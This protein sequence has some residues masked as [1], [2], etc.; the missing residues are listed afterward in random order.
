MSYNPILYLVSFEG[1]RATT[2]PPLEHFGVM[3][4]KHESLVIDMRH[5]KTYESI[6]G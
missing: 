1:A 6:V 4:Y 5:L 3:H 2:K